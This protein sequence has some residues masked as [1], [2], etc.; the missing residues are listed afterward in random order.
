MS[1]RCSLVLCWVVVGLGLLAFPTVATSK[2]KKELQ[3]EIEQERHR[4]LELNQ[5]IR[6]TQ[7]KAKKVENEQD[8]VLKNIENLDR[9]LIRK[10]DEFQKINRQLKKKDQ[11]LSDM[12]AHIG[13]LRAT[14]KKQQH[15]V[16]ARLRLLYMEGRDGYLKA[17]LS[18]NSFSNFERRLGY[19]STITKQ[20]YQ[21]L[22]TFHADLKSLE[23]LK[24]QQAQARNE[25]LE[26]KRK[27][28]KTIGDIRGVKNKK[29]VL[30]TSLSKKK[31]L[32]DRSVEGL[33]RSAD[34]VDGLVK[35]L[36]QRFKLSQSESRAP[37]PRP[38][39]LG[40]LLWPTEGKVVTTFGRQKHR[41]HDTYINEKGIKIRTKKGTP[42]RTV[43]SGE[44]VYADWLKGYGLV[45]IIDHQN[46]FFSLYAHASKL[47]VNEGD[48]VE[49]GTVI[50]ETGQTGLTEE[51]TLYFELR[52]GTKPVNPLKWLVKRP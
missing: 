29:K 31:Q 47:L 46:G 9:K 20:E 30:L 36:D 22:Q 12:K 7:E 40:S 38:L 11:E 16:A 43:S 48:S 37:S 8:S 6:E 35:D 10:Q 17:L 42:I 13:E 21:L 50:G 5:E 15:S 19:L 41:K 3:Q 28:E 27:T 52:K 23:Q 26:Y 33:Q 39:S 24:Q 2:E 14:T 32:F 18:S 1:R 45:V 44:V 25:L 34:R 49:V 51:N 4:L